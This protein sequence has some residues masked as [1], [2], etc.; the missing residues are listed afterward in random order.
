MEIDALDGDVLDAVLPEVSV[1]AR[2]TPA[3][4]VRVIRS[5]QRLGK[6]VAMTGDGA[7]DAPAIRPRWRRDRSWET[8]HSGSA[9]RRGRG[10]RRRQVRDDSGC[11]GRGPGNVGLGQFFGCSPLGPLGPTTAV[12]ACVGGTLLSKVLEPVAARRPG[13]RRACAPLS[14][15]WS[16]STTSHQAPLL[17]TGNRGVASRGWGT[18]PHP[19]PHRDGAPQ[20]RSFQPWTGRLP[21]MSAPGAA[22]ATRS[23]MTSDSS[24]GDQRP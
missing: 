10:R 16:A 17:P 19:H 18:H 13:R 7:N 21:V 6:M 15:S 8:R 11:A 5:C 4:K 14:R 20:P 12:G 9:G 22:F 1:V 24:P 2:G 3:H 23:G